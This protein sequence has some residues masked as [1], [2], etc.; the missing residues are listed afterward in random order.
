[1]EIKTKIAGMVMMIVMAT[2]TVV[3][4]TIVTVFMVIASQHEAAWLFNANTPP[5]SLCSSINPCSGAWKEGQSLLLCI[6]RMGM[7]RLSSLFR[8]SCLEDWSMRA[9]IQA[10][11]FSLKAFR[12][13]EPSA[14]VGFGLR[15]LEGFRFT[16]EAK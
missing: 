10:P 2:M 5:S 8:N 7:V 6:L 9:K 11:W 1:M 3:D 15:G 12:R 13:R 16:L 14:K 4:V